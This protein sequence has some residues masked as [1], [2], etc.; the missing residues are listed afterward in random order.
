MIKWVMVIIF[1]ILMAT[2]VFATDDASTVATSVTDIA[3]AN[4]AG[5]FAIG[6]NGGLNFRYMFNN[7]FGLEIPVSGSY[8]NPYY[9]RQNSY[10]LNGTCGVNILLPIKNNFGVLLCFEPGVVLSGTQYFYEYNSQPGLPYVDTYGPY[11]KYD[12]YSD[13]FSAGITLGLEVEVFTN[14]IWDKLPANISIGSKIALTGM[15]ALD[16]NWQKNFYV[17][18]IVKNVDYLRIVG[19]SVSLLNSTNALTNFTIRYY[20]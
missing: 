4:Y 18:G 6:Y 2:M 1:T 8:S 20:F 11:N 10:Y 3:S 15:G 12:Q 9:S 14:K 13:L 5:K 19:G 17:N 7:G 16:E